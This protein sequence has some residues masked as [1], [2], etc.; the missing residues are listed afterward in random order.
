MTNSNA[1]QKE[2]TGFLGEELACRFLSQKGFS[3]I[4]R[5]YRKKWGEIDIISRNRGTLHFVEV[6]T[7][8]RH[9]QSEN[10]QTEEFLPEENIHP[11]KLKRLS[12]TINSYLQEH[13]RDDAEKID[14]QIDAVIVFL[15]QG[16]KKANIRFLEAIGH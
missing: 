8:S 3:V 7:V 2:E 5:N 15:D 12:R 1:T 10:D 9:H 14:W 6:K 4:E 11:W 16:I 13:Y